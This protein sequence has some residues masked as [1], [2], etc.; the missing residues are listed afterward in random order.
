MKEKKVKRRLNK[1]A[2]LVILLTLY[3]II[4]AFYYCFTLPIKNIII[5]GNHLVS[6]TDIIEAAGIKNYPEI[7]KT[8]SN[9]IIENV[10][11]LN[12]IEDVNVK[13]RLNGT[14]IINVVESK[15]LFYNIFFNYIK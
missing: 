4:M 15:T 2:L 3:L 6:D 1:K 8:S 10:S 14:I 12:Y 5:E 11:A 9:K 7:F 13:K